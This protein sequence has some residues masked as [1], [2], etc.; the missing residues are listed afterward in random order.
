M[1]EVINLRKMR[2]KLVRAQDGRKAF[3]N[4]L[5]HG[6]SSAERAIESARKAKSRRDLDGH[7]IEREDGR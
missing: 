4:R 3:A 2:K 7:R 6:R 5:L 1:G